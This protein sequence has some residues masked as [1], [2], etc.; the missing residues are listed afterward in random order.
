MARVEYSSDYTGTS[1][2]IAAINETF[3][4]EETVR[5]ICK[6]CASNDVAEVLLLLSKKKSTP[7][8]VAIAEKLVAEKSP[9]PISIVWQNLPFA[10]G[11]YRDGIAAARGSHVLMMSA[12]LETDPSLVC[13]MLKASR[14]NP[15]AVVTMS[16]WIR[17]GGFTGYSKI[18]K[19]CNIIFQRCFS[20]LFLTRLSDLTYAFRNFPTD[21]MRKIGWKELRHPF[22]LETALVPLRLGVRFIE[23]PAHWN[24]RVEAE[25][26][27]SFFANFNYFKTAFRVRFTPWKLLL[28]KKTTQDSGVDKSKVG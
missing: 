10:G 15:D 2:M 20:L 23:L 8:C 25:S 19:I 24:Q 26:Q 16:R 1:I 6:T 27:N 28:L 9:Y 21:L 22:F 5:I 11:A 17:G 18:K 4:L 13:G 7:E 3:S 12:D 14:E